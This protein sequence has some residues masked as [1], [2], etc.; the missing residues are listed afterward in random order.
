M[1]HYMELSNFLEYQL[2]IYPHV[3]TPVQVLRYRWWVFLSLETVGGGGEQLVS[4]LEKNLG[5]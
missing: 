4:N 5:K 1:S 3:I 2:C